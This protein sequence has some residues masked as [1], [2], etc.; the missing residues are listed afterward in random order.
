MV[1][2][3]PD[4]EFEGCLHRRVWAPTMWTERKKIERRPASWSAKAQ[5]RGCLWFSAERTWSG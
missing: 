1:K 4:V 5:Y 2:A 3:D